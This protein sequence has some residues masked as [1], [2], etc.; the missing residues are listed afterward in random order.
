LTDQV[1]A[2]KVKA[3]LTAV[4]EIYITLNPD[5]SVGAEAFRRGATEY[6]QKTFSRTEKPASRPALTY[7]D[8]VD[9]GDDELMLA[10]KAG[11]NDALAVLLDRYQRLVFSIVLRIVR[12]RQ[13]AEDVMQNVFLD[14]FRAVQL[15]DP[16]K[17]TTKAWL[18]EYAY[19]RA[20]N[21]WR[22]LNS[23]KFYQQ[24]SIDETDLTHAANCWFVRYT[25][26][27]LRMLLEQGLS[28]LRDKERR[29]I[30]LVS[31]EGLSMK[32]VAEKTGESVVNVRHRYYRG[33][34]RLRA[35][36]ERS[37]QPKEG[38]VRPTNSVNRPEQR[39]CETSGT[40]RLAA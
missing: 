36:V 18:L 21:R 3:M 23:R 17:G 38:R 10:L 33:L 26:C 39:Q 34:R 40:N 9:L 22:Q 25:R 31:Y 7:S 4:K 30:E 6:V 16:A 35:F 11:C 19:H 2:R 29:V 24:E 1:V 12:D 37:P 20:I 5:I 14:V 32:E 15:F 8:L 27:E 13:E 28:T